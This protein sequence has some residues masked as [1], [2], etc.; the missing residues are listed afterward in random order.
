MCCDLWI[1]WVVGA[2]GF[3]LILVLYD[4]CTYLLTYLLYWIGAES[5]PFGSLPVAEKLCKYYFL[6]QISRTLLFYL[7]YFIWLVD[8][9]APGVVRII[10]MGMYVCLSV[11][12]S[13]RIARNHKAFTKIVCML[14]KAVTRSSFGDV[15]IRYVLPVLWMTSRFRT[16]ALWHAMW[17]PKRT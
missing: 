10:V 3:F 6:L 16:M 12:L 9:F 7:Q 15:A 8:Y 1:D 13:A 17:I 2:H 11:C 4:W 14:P 5:R